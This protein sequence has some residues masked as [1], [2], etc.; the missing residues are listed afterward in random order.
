MNITFLLGTLPADLRQTSCRPL[1]DLQQPTL[2]VEGAATIQFTAPLADLQQTSGRHVN[3]ERSTTSG[4]P[5]ADT[6]TS[7]IPPPPPPP[8]ALLRLRRLYKYCLASGNF[9]NC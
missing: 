3:L 9:I 6:F 7:N 4:R 2:K 8:G 5:P 1:A